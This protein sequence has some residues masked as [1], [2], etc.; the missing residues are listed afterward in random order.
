MKIQDLAKLAGVS[1][2][3]VSRVFGHH[4]NVRS[5]VRERVLAAAR[6]CG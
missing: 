1:T 3:T 5:E 4:P 2:A 6:R